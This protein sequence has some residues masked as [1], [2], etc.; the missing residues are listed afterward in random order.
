MS[1]EIR[2]YSA[3]MIFALVFFVGCSKDKDDTPNSGTGSIDV[4]TGTFKGTIR[5]GT[6]NHFNAILT[7]SK[8]DNQ[9]LKVVAKSG[10]PYSD[11]TTKTIQVK[12]DVPGLV[13]GH[14]DQ[15]YF[16]YE[17]E[18]KKLTVLTKQTGA[19]EIDYGFEGIK[20]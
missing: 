12:A 2:M 1:L 16:A 3:M 7:V 19:S 14:D 18:K 8:V 6:T 17:I 15:G 4:A 5:I 11:V 13:D 10:E 20:Q 9:R